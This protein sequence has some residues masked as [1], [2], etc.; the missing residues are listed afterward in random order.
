MIVGWTSTQHG[1]TPTQLRAA[2]DWIVRLETTQLHHGDCIGGDEQIHA[3]C[4]ALGIR[5]VL[6]P[7]SDSSKRAF[8][9]GAAVILEP[10][11]YLDRNHDIVDATQALVAAPKQELEQV[12]SGTW[13][14]VRYA[15]SRGRRVIVVGPTVAGL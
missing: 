2:A 5:V 7:P 11:P 3:V 4:L 15:R 9:E 8:C 12:R 14:T 6:H 10:R 13:A 1:L